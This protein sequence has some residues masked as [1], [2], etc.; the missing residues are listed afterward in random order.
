VNYTIEVIS[1]EAAATSSLV[2]PMPSWSYQICSANYGADDCR[3]S[4]TGCRACTVSDYVYSVSSC[5]FDLRETVHTELSTTQCSTTA[6]G[7]VILPSKLYVNCDHV[8]FNSGAGV[9]LLVLLILGV[10]GTLACAVWVWRNRRLKVVLAAQPVFLLV[11]LFGALFV[12][13]GGILCLGPNT[14]HRCRTR[15]WMLSVFFTLCFSGL[16]MKIYRVWRIFGNKRLVK[17]KITE[18]DMAKGL[19]SILLCDVVPLIAWSILVSPASTTSITDSYGLEY[20]YHT[21]KYNSPALLFVLLLK[22]R[23]ASTQQ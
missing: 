22:V 2:Y 13:V 19:A 8:P 1:P 12:L 21:C 18:R 17:L 23:R 16:V 6:E 7:A 11:F 15:V 20:T 14:A 5:S 3:C 10:L 4:S 9:S